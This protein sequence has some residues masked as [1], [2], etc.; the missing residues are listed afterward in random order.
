MS[1][2]SIIICLSIIVLCA[3][4]LRVDFDCDTEVC[5]RRETVSP[6]TPLEIITTLI[7]AVIRDINTRMPLPSYEVL[8]A[9]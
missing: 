1:I 5:Y 9:F 3:H 4:S 6:M 8:R 7:V 2:R